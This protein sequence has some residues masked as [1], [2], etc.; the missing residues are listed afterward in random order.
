MKRDEIKVGGVYA[1]LVSGRVQ[2]IRIVRE[3]GMIKKWQGMAGTSKYKDAFGGWFGKNEKHGPGGSG[4]FRSQVPL[5]D[6]TLAG[7][8][9]APVRI[10]V[11]QPGCLGNHPG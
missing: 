5:F 7:P 11:D 3:H 9:L 1:I 6:G 2:P 10:R 4:P 8:R